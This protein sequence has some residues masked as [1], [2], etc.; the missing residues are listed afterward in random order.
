M[1]THKK[2]IQGKLLT[3][4]NDSNVEWVITF[5]GHTDRYPKNKWTMKDAISF[6][7]ELWGEK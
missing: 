5:N 2:T 1:T 4:Y 7:V 3:A 6:M